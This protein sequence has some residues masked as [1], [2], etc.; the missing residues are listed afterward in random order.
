MKILYKL[1]LVIFLS[2]GVLTAC[3]KKANEELSK[4]IEIFE[5]LKLIAGEINI[6]IDSE[7]DSAQSYIDSKPKVA[8][9]DKKAITKLQE[10]VD[11]YREMKITIDNGDSFSIEEFD[12]A[13]E[14]LENAIALVD[15]KFVD[16]LN[17]NDL[18]LTK[19]R[20]IV[21]DSAVFDGFFSSDSTIKN[22]YN[23]ITKQR[24]VVS[25]AV[26]KEEK[27]L[28]KKAASAALKKKKANCK[29]DGGWWETDHCEY[30]G[31]AKPVLYLYP[32]R[33]TNVKVSFEKP[34]LLTVTYPKFVEAWE[35][36][37]YPNGDLYDSDNKYYYALYWEEKLENPV[38]FKTGFYVEAKD[39]INFLEE[40]LTIIG[41]NERER[42]E[43]IMYWLPILEANQKSLVYFELTEERQAGKKLFIQPVLD[44]L[45]RIGI[46]IMKVEVKT[47]I[48]PQKLT[49]FT[50]KGF[51]AV[52]WGG[53]LYR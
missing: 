34:Q 33:K 16:K 48:E 44:S 17:I 4:R 37:A 24:K 6:A 9:K 35:V 47:D 18:T 11:E 14:G 49:S 40:K 51:V 15:D 42:N 23:E 2:V 43:F 52:E 3:D 5:K 50:R 13:I 29:K 12:K 25:D 41:L 8:K 27:R 28:A 30:G 10:L 19:L 46:H 32:T 36:T 31:R 39:A 26:E 21:F 45:L 20:E 53:T 1:I 22:K 7:A 38:N